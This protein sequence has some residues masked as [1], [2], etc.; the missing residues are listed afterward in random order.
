MEF[1]YIIIEEMWL[2]NVTLTVY[3]IIEDMWLISVTLT[4]YI[5]GDICESF[6]GFR[7]YFYN[8][9]TIHIRTENCIWMIQ[10]KHLSKIRSLEY[11]HVR[12]HLYLR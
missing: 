10:P 12:N 7:N 5:S 4:V 2:I 11:I 8:I 1:G 3:I 9:V 6:S